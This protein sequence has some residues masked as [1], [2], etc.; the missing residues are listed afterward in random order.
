MKSIEIFESIQKNENSDTTGLSKELYWAYERSCERDCEI[1]DF[2]DS[3]RENVIVEIVDCMKKLDIHEFT[4]SSGWSSTIEML[5]LFEKYGC[6][7]VGATN[8]N[9]FHKDW[10]TGVRETKPAILFSL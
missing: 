7:I 8:V 4:V 10:E 1:I 5:C 9:S 6:K 3:F 2:D